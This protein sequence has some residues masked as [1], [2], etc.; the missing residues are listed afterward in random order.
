MKKG[1]V[2]PKRDYRNIKL[3]F[4]TLINNAAC[5][6]AG[7]HKPWYPAVIMFILSCFISVIPVTVNV[8]KTN[9]S[10][11]MSGQF[12]GKNF[13]TPAL[14]FVKELSKPENDI[15]MIVK[16]DPINTKEKYLIVD[17]DKW[18]AT[19][20]DTLGDV[21]YYVHHEVEVDNE[22]NKKEGKA[23]FKAFYVNYDDNKDPSTYINTLLEFRKEILKKPEV[24][25]GESQPE[26]P[27]Q[28]FI[29]HRNYLIFDNTLD[30]K[31]A[32]TFTG[33]WMHLRD[34]YNLKDMGGK[35]KADS[36]KPYEN[37]DI[38]TDEWKNVFDD[39]YIT[40]KKQTNV[41]RS[42]LI[43]G[44]NLI[45]VLFMGLMIFILTRGKNNPFHVYT[46][47]QSQKIAYW[48]TVSP[49]L[50]ALIC[51]FFL[52]NFDIMLFPMLLG[53]RIMWLSMK[54]LRPEPAPS[55]PRPPKPQKEKKESWLARHKAKKALKAQEKADAKLAKNSEKVEDQ[56]VL[57]HAPEV[58][59]IDTT[60]K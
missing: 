31:S 4:T 14:A 15:N 50:L 2:K 29:F 16:K 28:F 42:L 26:K 22:G 46:F 20:K 35:Y 41:N 52:K 13:A 6:D 9:G 56:K 1:K 7:R 58:K 32:P 24:K 3:F 18:N 11:F 33:D 51:G 44:I 48:S 54:T 12:E 23:D 17:E 49:A 30:D 37:A 34:N 40:F 53:I 36:S 59:E 5:V 43:L 60:K 47:W 45:L 55:A 25:E 38:I 57:N 8:H 10:D 21:H 19:F 27:I 39:S